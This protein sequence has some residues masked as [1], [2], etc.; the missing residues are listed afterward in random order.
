L[1]RCSPAITTSTVAAIQPHP[2][3]RH[4]QAVVQRERDD[5]HQRDGDQELEKSAPHGRQVLQVH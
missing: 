3:N 4:A 5:V 1:R 2:K